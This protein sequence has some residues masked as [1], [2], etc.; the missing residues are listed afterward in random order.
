M[1][2]KEDFQSLK[3][4]LMKEKPNSP[5]YKSISLKFKLKLKLFYCTLEVCNKNILLYKSHC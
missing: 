5:K 1:P 2:C 3:Q 4:K